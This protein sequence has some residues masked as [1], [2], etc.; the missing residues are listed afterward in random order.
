M[1]R[2]FS[3][4]INPKKGSGASFYKGAIYIELVELNVTDPD[5][6]KNG[7]PKACKSALVDDWKSGNSRA[8]VVLNLCRS[9]SAGPNP[10]QREGALSCFSH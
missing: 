10:E 6:D 5:R 1:N 4:Q 8:L 9:A 3:K 7:G 2:L